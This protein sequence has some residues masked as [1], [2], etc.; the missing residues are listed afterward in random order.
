VTTGASVKVQPTTFANIPSAGG[1]TSPTTAPEEE[2][3]A[4]ATSNSARKDSLS[5]AGFV[6]AGLLAVIAAY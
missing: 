1:S 3:P 6:G 4:Q 5:A 2:A